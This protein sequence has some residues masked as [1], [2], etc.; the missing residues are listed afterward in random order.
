MRLYQ[1]KN[2]LYKKYVKERLSCEEIGRLCGVHRTTVY[3]W[4][5]HYGIKT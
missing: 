5:V 1:D 3:R 2:W 4:L